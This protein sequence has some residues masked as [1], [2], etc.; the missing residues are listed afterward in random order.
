M[1]GVAR[2]ALLYFCFFLPP[3]LHTVHSPPRAATA[4]GSQPTAPSA[5]ESRETRVEV[6]EQCFSK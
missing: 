1:R 3:T 2:L 5:R 4:S 6:E